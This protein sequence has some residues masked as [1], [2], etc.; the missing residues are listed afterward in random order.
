MSINV[1]YELGFNGDYAFIDGKRF[2]DYGFMW[3]DLHKLTGI[4]YETLQ[5][6]DDWYIL[7]GG[8]YY[9]KKHCVFEELFMS[10]LASICKVKCVEFKLASVD[11][12]IGVISKLY[13]ENN[14]KYYM[15]TDFCRKYF[16]HVPDNLRVLKLA[17][18]SS[19][20]DK[21]GQQL[22]D[23]IFNL[24]CFD[25]F[26]GQWD[27]EEHNFFF[28]CDKNIVSLAPLCDNGM[29]FSGNFIYST[30]FAKFSLSSIDESVVYR[31]NLFQIL[32]F[33]EVFFNKL[34]ALLDIDINE[35]IKR[36]LEKYKIFIADCD[37]DYILEYFDERKKA[38]DLTLKLSRNYGR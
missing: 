32:R 1:G 34:A 22:M 10:E 3:K 26:S 2:S 5:M 18:L 13:R 37:R 31:N 14:K 9:F 25:I 35:V 15:Y 4:D 23:D 7:E 27:R 12:K 17:S 19:F 11:D 21:I 6:Y 16:N 38:I 36:T 8:L 24:V 30:P 20:G 33:D 29:I 28:E